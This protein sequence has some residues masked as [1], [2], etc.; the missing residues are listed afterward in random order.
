M[1]YLKPLFGDALKIYEGVE[2]QTQHNN[3][4]YS[5]FLTHG[6]QGDKRSD[7]NPVSMWI[8]AAIWTPIQRFL[9]IN[10]N[11]TADSFELIDAHNIIMYE[12]SAQQKQLIFISGHTHKPVF[13]SFDHID[14][15]NHQL[16][17]AK[18][19]AD[20]AA[21]N[22]I[23]TDLAVYTKEYEGKKFIKSM[24]YPSY[25]NSGCCC[26]DDGDCTGI[27]IEGGYIRL[28]KWETKTEGGTE[29]KVLEESPLSYI[30]DQLPQDV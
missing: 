19:A 14:L 7:G 26:F 22:K 30:F 3:K 9:D 4:T 5:I 27:E 23:E 25:F 21:I 6:H 13:A 20:A 12:W 29:K 1:L 11:V 8:V 17:D 16:Q 24:A 28:V 10:V 15:L 18:L 2:L